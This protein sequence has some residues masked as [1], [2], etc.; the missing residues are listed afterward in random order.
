VDDLN[1][2]IDNA[3]EATK[4]HAHVAKHVQHAAALARFR[5]HDADGGP[6]YTGPL[7]DGV[8]QPPRQPLLPALQGEV[9][10]LEALQYELVWAADCAEFT[11]A[12]NNSRKYRQAAGHVEL[13]ARAWLGP[14]GLTRWPAVFVRDLAAAAH[15]DLETLVPAMGTFPPTA[16]GV[17]ARFAWD[18]HHE[19]P[20]SDPDDLGRRKLISYRV[21]PASLEPPK[22]QPAPL[23]DR[24]KQVTTPDELAALA[25]VYARELVEAL[26]APEAFA[27]TVD[28]H[29]SS[30]QLATPDGPLRLGEWTVIARLDGS[31]SGERLDLRLPAAAAAALGDRDIV[32]SL[33]IG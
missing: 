9:P 18:I 32:R 24:L 25:P 2:A 20:V 16:G 7:S 5:A 31:P 19:N 27:R 11:D 23:G 28:V 4:T 6:Y 1:Q 29:M 12:N 3:L 13:A 30:W 33:E 21:G 10:E 15:L 26:G 22:L 8:P 17:F 14:E